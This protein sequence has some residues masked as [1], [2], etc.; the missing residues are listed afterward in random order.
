MLNHW[1]VKGKII[2]FLDRIKEVN[3]LPDTI[4]VKDG[5]SLTLMHKGK[6][7][8]YDSPL[9]YVSWAARLMN[10]KYKNYLRVGII[11]NKDTEKIKIQKLDN[12]HYNLSYRGILIPGIRQLLFIGE[13]PKSDAKVMFENTK[14]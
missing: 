10:K 9:A 6:L 4:I 8:T 3:K 13:L 14:I 12:T 5:F 11:D 7:E 1:K 2:F